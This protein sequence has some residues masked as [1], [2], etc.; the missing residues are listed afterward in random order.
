MLSIKDN[1][2]VSY[3]IKTVNR[4]NANIVAYYSD[5][6]KEKG[7]GREQYA[8]R[9]LAHLDATIE[10]APCGSETDC[11]AKWDILISVNDKVYPLQ[12]K[13]SE[14]G[15]LLFEEKNPKLNGQSIAHCPCLVLEDRLDR[16]FLGYTV[17]MQIISLFKNNDVTVALKPEVKS[18]IAQYKK[19]KSGGTKAI[20]K[21]IQRVV[22][23]G[24]QI[25]ILKD[26]GLG[27]DFKGSFHLF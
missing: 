20:G 16:A 25:Q 15:R 17:L 1:E 2:W 18:A 6:G 3:S 11:R 22:F 14:Q 7:L 10:L 13:S 26:L 23:P 19:L 27:C 4:A 24:N 5:N 12:V 21:S 9:I 8:L